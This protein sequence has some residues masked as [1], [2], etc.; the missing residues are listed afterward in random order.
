MIATTNQLNIKFQ[1][2]LIDKNFDFF[3]L[4]TTE[5]YIA[6]GA[7]VLDKPNLELK[8]QSV[9]FENGKILYVMFA[10]GT[11]SKYEFIRTINEEH[12][13][14]NHVSCDDIKDY[15]LFRLFLYSLNNFEHENLT[16]NN[17]TGKLYI[18]SPEW[19]K[20]DKSSFVALHI[21]VDN[22]LYLSAEATT[23][24]QYCR[25]SETKKLKEYAKYELAN[26][27]HALKRVLADNK[28]QGTYIKKGIYNKKADIPF[29]LL[30]SKDISKS[31][32]YYIYLVL[33]LLKQRFGSYLDFSFKTINVSK[34]I[35][36]TKDSSFMNH[37]L[38]EF[39]KKP[40]I[41]INKVLGTEYVETFEDIVSSIN[42]FSSADGKIGGVVDRSANNIVLIHNKDYYEQHKYSDVHKTLPRNAVIQCITV[43][44]TAE[45]II[46][47]KK[48]II[49]TIIKEIVIK[50]DILFAG[51]F[52]LDDWT[53][54][55]FTS[56]YVFGK[57][58]DG[59][60]YFITVHPDGTFELNNKVDD[61][62]SFGNDVLDR[63]SALL[64][65]NKGKEKVIV[66]D[67]NGNV[68]IVS[69]TN[70]YALPPREIFDLETISR[71]AESREK[72][73][74]GVVDINL[75][76]SADGKFYYNVGIQ[77]YGMNTKIIHAPLLYQVDIISGINIMNDLL[78]TMSVSFVKY[79]SFTVLPYPIK[80]LNEYILMKEND[81]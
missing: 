10:K 26:K 64:S 47:D 79:K 71:S 72:Y 22:E 73:L 37:A 69:R 43:E 32:V 6:G 78:A 39:L 31:K 54:F 17:I 70:R 21:D 38:E 80:Y 75:Y 36:R 35:G 63:C 49:E 1:R 59:A 50:N 20:K 68:N 42:K 74:A 76:D 24:A 5:K 77:G 60:H 66:S 14:I 45:S 11:I 12:L 46:D 19:M 30:S 58:K 23:F 40:L 8:A 3:R 62:S 27:N 51:R 44:D 29:F 81:K 56:D 16:F 67:C 18:C 34:S 41:F 65:S 4:S 9:A 28:S 33:D 2:A 7:Y 13:V 48:A 25:F 61:F 15:V 53:S 57:E 55:N 52:T